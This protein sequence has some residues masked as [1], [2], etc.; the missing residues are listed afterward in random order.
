MP[1]N[2]HFLFASA[3]QFTRFVRARALAAA[4]VAGLSACATQPPAPVV[5]ESAAPPGT[6]AGVL[7]A[8][9]AA[10]TALAPPAST[11]GAAASVPAPRAGTLD[12]SILT[13]DVRGLYRQHLK[14]ANGL[15]Y[16][17]DPAQSDIRIFAFRAGLGARFGRNHVI[18]VPQ[19]SGLAWV[20]DSGL[21]G[22]SAHFSFRIGDLA[23]DPPALRA[24]TGGGFAGTLGTADSHAILEHLMGERGFQA[25]T[26]P[27]VQASVTVDTGEQPVAIADVA[28]SL[29]G[30][31]HHQRVVLKVH[32]DAQQIE[33]TGSLAFRQ[34]DFGL[35]P[36]AVLGGLMAVDELVAVEFHLRGTVLAPGSL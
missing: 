7:A 11:T 16:G 12:F 35:K 36:Y 9:G 33:A 32:A 19:F 4:L 3:A 28:L 29:H 5:P 8:S 30:E 23:V 2:P 17:L 27:L 25:A 34:G 22:G 18:A 26:F 6:K 24:T 14:D 10:G 1:P 20:P 21:R 15:T 31:T 13:S